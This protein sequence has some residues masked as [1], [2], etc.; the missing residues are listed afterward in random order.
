LKAKEPQAI[1]K[2]DTEAIFRAAERNAPGGR[3]ALRELVASEPGL[4][5]IVPVAM[6]L[7]YYVESALRKHAC[8]GNGVLE[9][10]LPQELAALRGALARR[11]DGGLEQLLI[12][13]VVLSWLV[14]AAAEHRR[15]SLWLGG[16][17]GHERAQFWD[18]RVSRLAG[19]FAR[20]CRTLA[21]VR[22]LLVP[23][24]GQ[25]NVAQQQVN[26]ATL[27]SEEGAVD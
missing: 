23:A 15:A 17:V 22:R 4:A 13:R 6:G 2:P 20:A 16:E 27:S 18:R 10:F 24:I 26:V 3:E 8:A 25:L 11:G 9:E 7:A 12:E 1:A 14:L 21:T 19:D 5:E